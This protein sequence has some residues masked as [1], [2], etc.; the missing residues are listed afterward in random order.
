[1]NEYFAIVDEE[2]N[3]VGKATYEEMVKDGVIHRSANIMVFNS[4]GKLFCHQRALGLK[5]YPGLWDVK[6]GGL[7]DYGETYEA[8]AKRELFEEASIKVSKIKPLFKLKTR[9]KENMTN[10]EVFS[11][12][13]DGEI[14]LDP[15]EVAEGKFLTIKE[16][17]K[18]GESCK[19]SP[20]GKEILSKY[21][22]LIK[23]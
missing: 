14:N 15:G 21:F 2:D 19:M 7:V 16:A 6:F 23:K 18:L 4:G 13:Y 8:A 11:C 17:L 9:K 1:M 5:L 20:S 3:L 22:G 10:R 12:V